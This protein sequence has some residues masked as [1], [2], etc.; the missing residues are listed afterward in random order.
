MELVL[1]GKHSSVCK[2]GFDKKKERQTCVNMYVVLRL[3]IKYWGANF[4][5]AQSPIKLP[6]PPR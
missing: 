2:L 6:Q 5:R 1:C 3:V 4:F